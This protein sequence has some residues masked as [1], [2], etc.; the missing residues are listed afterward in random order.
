[1]DN[2]RRHIQ[3]GTGVTDMWP[4]EN[5]VGQYVYILATNGARYECMPA[6]PPIKLLVVSHNS[7][8]LDTSSEDSP[9][10]LLD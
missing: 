5:G 6:I 8:F 4:S 2:E 10:E 9:R 7:K 3:R 1:M